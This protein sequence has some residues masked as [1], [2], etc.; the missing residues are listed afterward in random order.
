MVCRN[1]TC[2]SNCRL[3]YALLWWLAHFNRWQHQTNESLTKAISCPTVD[4]AASAAAAVIGSCQPPES[5]AAH[6]SIGATP[7]TAAH[8]ADAGSLLEAH[9]SAE[10]PA[11]LALLALLKWADSLCGA[12][13]AAVA[14]SGGHSRRSSSGSGWDSASSSDG[15]HG[16]IAPALSFNVVLDERQHGTQ[17]LLHSGLSRLQGECVCV[18]LLTSS[19]LPQ[20]R[21]SAVF[22]PEYSLGLVPVGRQARGVK[23]SHK[24][25]S[26]IRGMLP[27][28]VL[29]TAPCLLLT[30]AGPALCVAIKGISSLSADKLGQLLQWGAPLARTS[31]SAGP[32]ASASAAG[33]AAIQ[34][35]LSSAWAVTDVLQVGQGLAMVCVLGVE[36]SLYLGT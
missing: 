16:R 13:A 22:P 12:D 20:W 18:C 34:Q 28:C 26:L 4:T 5:S 3:R 23:L 25:S 36:G 2:L 1:C 19:N 17:S 6:T 15:Y 33:P 11:L 14:A 27:V 7:A 30:P 10:G 32:S 29:G 24:S 31:S 8:A 35:G 21:S 9:P